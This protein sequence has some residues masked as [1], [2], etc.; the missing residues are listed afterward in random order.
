[1]V[2]CRTTQPNARGD[3][4]YGMAVKPTLALVLVASLAACSG[5]GPAPQPTPSLPTRP[6]P[7]PAP[8][9]GTSEPVADP[10]YPAF[11]NPAI[12]VIRYSLALDWS[13]STRT[14]AGTATLTV[15]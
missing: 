8:A 9:D 11:G 3:R 5:G 7:P 2:P 14:L 1:M 15:R 10:V 6:A 13:A 12:D 4:R